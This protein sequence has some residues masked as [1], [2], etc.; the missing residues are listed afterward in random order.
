MQVNRKGFK[1]KQLKLFRSVN[2]IV[3][4]FTSLK[5]GQE[6][7]VKQKLLGAECFVWQ[8]FLKKH[9]QVKI[10]RTR[11]VQVPK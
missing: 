9:K 2:R 6:S 8:H 11:Y 10:R 7:N 5:K 4:L 1:P 3:D